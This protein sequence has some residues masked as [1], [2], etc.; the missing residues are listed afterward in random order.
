MELSESQGLHL[1][2][3]WFLNEKDHKLVMKERAVQ[4]GVNINI[5]CWEQQLGILE[6]SNKESELG[7]NESCRSN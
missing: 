7:S 3:E 1:L 5:V 4:T 2:K 6:S